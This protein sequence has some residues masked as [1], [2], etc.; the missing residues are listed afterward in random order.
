LLWLV[1]PNAPTRTPT[2]HFNAER[3]R[4]EL[5]KHD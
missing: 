4:Q 2:G 3:Q 5:R 1:R